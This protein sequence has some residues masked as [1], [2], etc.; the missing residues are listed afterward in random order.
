MP[1]SPHQLALAL[2][3]AWRMMREARMQ[4]FSD[5]LQ[6]NALRSDCLRPVCLDADFTEKKMVV[7]HGTASVR[8]SKMLK[9]TALKTAHSND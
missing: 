4:T 7:V 6:A 2:D 3:L 5:G 8:V 1:I 9:V